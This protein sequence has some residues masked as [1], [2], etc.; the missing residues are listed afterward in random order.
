MSD[1]MSPRYHNNPNPGL[2][3]SLFKKWT[4]G[5]W[6]VLLLTGG[7][8]FF[9]TLRYNLLVGICVAPF[10]L[11]NV[12]AFYGHLWWDLTGLLHHAFVRVVL[13]NKIYVRSDM[14]TSSKLVRWLRQ[15]RYRRAENRYVFPIYPTVVPIENEYMG[16]L[17]QV[18]RPYAAIPARGHGSDFNSLDDYSQDMATLRLANNFDRISL[19]AREQWRLKIGISPVGLARPI[20]NQK[21]SKYIARNGQ[22][23]VFMTELFDLHPAE[24]EMMLRL[25]H[26]A[27]QILPTLQAY[28]VTENWQLMLMTVKHDGDMKK[29]LRNQLSEKGL[30]D[31]RLIQLGRMMVE[32][33][34]GCGMNVRKPHCLSPLE[35][36]QLIRGGW[37]VRNSDFMDH[38]E[39]DV[40][41]LVTEDDVNAPGSQYTEHD[42]GS[43]KVPFSIYPEESIEAYSDHMVMDGNYITSYMVTKGLSQFHVRDMQRAYHLER[44]AG[45]FGSMASAGETISSD[46]QTDISVY[47]QRFANDLSTVLNPNPAMEHPKKR[48][49][50]HATQAETEEL[51]LASLAQRHN[52]VGTIVAPDK[53]TMLAQRADAMASLQNMG[54]KCRVIRGAHR[55]MAAFV[56]GVYG[57]NRL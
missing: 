2:R 19:L 24:E 30:R 16:I 21:Y 54:F 40:V 33:I 13:K 56:T 53:K 3:F 52:D 11:L 45:V 20:G 42:I 29:A 5:D 37:D 6:S 10:L 39:G 4:L 25:R 49:Q 34:E 55:Q 50:R 14:D 48:R 57:I 9:M 38:E 27:E 7:L 47:R 51:S 17:Q 43:L 32:A 18:D 28:G 41:E 26:N 36:C 22:P 44:R 35:L 1:Q 15:Q 23:L 12:Q 8:V 46:V 31:L